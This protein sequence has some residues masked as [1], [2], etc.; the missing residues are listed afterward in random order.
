[1]P[2]GKLTV[3]TSGR[4]L[5]Q[6]LFV[7]LLL[8]GIVF[9]GCHARTI[10][11]TATDQDLK[12][13]DELMQEGDLAFVRK[14]FYA[15]LIKH[16]EAA[17]FNP[18]DENLLNRLGIDYVQLNLYRDAHRAFQSALDLNPK[19]SFA[20][21]NLGSVYFFQRKL[22]QAEKVFKKAINLKSDEASFHVNLGKLY[23]DK[24]KIAKAEVEWDKAIALDPAA[25]T[26]RGGV[27]LAVSGR[28][29][30]N[31]YYYY[32]ACFFASKG[33]VEPAIRN[34]KLAYSQGFSDIR[35]IEKEPAFNPIR[36]DQRFVDYMKDL[37]LQIKLRDRT[38]R[39]ES[40]GSPVPR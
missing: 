39:P 17:R 22:R 12:R 3:R 21:N 2:E 31:Q 29:S 8:S 11:V 20:W 4:N 18:N 35:A 40:Q 9:T 23:L 5:K 34:L 32:V 26:E 38:G 28:T 7:G 14:D 27:S 36:Q 33:S 1:V 25:L 19:F 30:P 6:R 37:S 24:K 16:L 13:S 15:A 10:R